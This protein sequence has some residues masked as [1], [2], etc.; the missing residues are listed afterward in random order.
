MYVCLTLER[1]A[2]SVAREVGVWE[3]MP[4]PSLLAEPS[5]PRQRRRRAVEKGHCGERMAERGRT[6][7]G[8]WGGFL[9]ALGAGWLSLSHRVESEFEICTVDRC[10]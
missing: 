4:A 9:L 2:T 3:M 8:E 6:R 10:K 7:F 1:T 5:S